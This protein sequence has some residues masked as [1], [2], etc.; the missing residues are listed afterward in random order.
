MPAM[1]QERDSATGVLNLRSRC[2][3]LGEEILDQQ[4]F[5]SRTF[6]S[7][8]SRYDPRTNRCYVEL[9]VLT[10]DINTIHRYLY[11]GQTKEMLAHAA[12]VKGNME[13]QIFNNERNPT[14]FAGYFE[15]SEYIDEMM[16][17]DRK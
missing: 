16:A 1:A 12:R 2:A 9:T 3:E 14:G 10:D 8:A 11:D 4:P 15:A 5:K 7:Q 17:E 6:P 13:G